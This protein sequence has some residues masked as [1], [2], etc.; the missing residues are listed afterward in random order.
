MSGRPLVRSPPLFCPVLMRPGKVDTRFS[1]T[2]N[3]NLS[4]KRYTNEF[5][6]EAV[7]YLVIEGES[8][9]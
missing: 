2:E 1:N 3:I 9:A 4:K 7:R 8:V 5:K 6:K